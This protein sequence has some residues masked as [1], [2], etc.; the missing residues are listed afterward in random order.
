MQDYSPYESYQVLGNSM[1]NIVEAFGSFSLIASRF[2]SQE[3]LGTIGADGLAQFEPGKWYPL[4]GNLKAL[5]RINSE[6]GE[7]V[8]QQ[9]AAAVLKNATFPPSVTDILSGLAALDIAYHMNHARGG[10]P[11]FS[12]QTGQ[13][14][15][16]IGNY[17]SKPIQGRKEV[18]L[19]C[20]NPYPCAFDQSLIQSMARRFEPTA[21]VAH[22]EPSQCRGKSGS[23]CTYSVIW[24]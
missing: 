16:G 6:F 5:A 13:L 8:L 23:S 9:A 18:Q 15:E 1:Q 3:G 21:T 14:R 20:N 10:E 7:Y 17:R 4:K 2:L 12:P 24:R 22:L 11:L 19:V